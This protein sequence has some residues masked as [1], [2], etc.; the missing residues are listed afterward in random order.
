MGARLKW[1]WNRRVLVSKKHLR[2]LILFGQHRNPES[3]SYC[4]LGFCLF[5]NR[6]RRP[7]ANT[8]SSGDSCLTEKGLPADPI[9]S[10][11][12]VK[13]CFI[14][15]LVQKQRIESHRWTHCQNASV[16]GYFCLARLQ[17]FSFQQS[18]PTNWSR[19]LHW[20][21]FAFQRR[22]DILDGPYH[23]VL[24]DRVVKLGKP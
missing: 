1:Y 21:T 17:F 16:R 15:S 13:D 19:W 20:F 3:L 4:R 2:Q 6:F 5:P 24:G 18:P 12:V 8:T 10:V 11:N 7:K 14:F 23:S 22:R 9:H